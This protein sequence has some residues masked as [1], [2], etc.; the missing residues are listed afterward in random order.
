MAAALH[1]TAQ[2]CRRRFPDA[3]GRGRDRGVLHCRRRGRARRDRQDCRARDLDRR[4]RPV[5]ARQRADH[6]GALQDRGPHRGD[7]LRAVQGALLPEP[8]VR[9][10]AA[11]ADRGP[12]A[13]QC[14]DP[15]PG[16]AVVNFRTSDTARPSRRRTIVTLRGGNFMPLPRRRLLQFAAAAV[17]AVTSRIARAYPTRPVRWIVGFP[18][19]GPADILARLLGQWLSERLGQQFVIE[20]RPG[21]GGNIS[22]E[23][24]VRAP[25]D[26]YTLLL[27]TTANAINATLYDKL[28]YNF[29]R[30]ITPVAGIIRVP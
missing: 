18:P 27:V 22:T 4:D 28:G 13:G 10:L 19:G 16:K 5:H 25:A 7:H 3:Q 12:A 20:N 30:D 29:I 17:L 23:A 21:A 8:A 9:L 2:L 14:R 6:V 24:V 26:G 15:A 11:A 1:A